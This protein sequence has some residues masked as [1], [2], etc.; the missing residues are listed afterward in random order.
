MF[1]TILGL[2]SSGEELEHRVFWCKQLDGMTDEG[3]VE[4]IAH[5]AIVWRDYGE[6]I[7]FDSPVFQF[8][9]CDVTTVAGSR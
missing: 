4:L 9:A 3:R 7:H 1:T 6:I 2:E 8:A 5:F